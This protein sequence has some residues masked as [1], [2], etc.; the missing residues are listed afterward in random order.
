MILFAEDHYAINVKVG[1]SCGM[2]AVGDG[3]QI[4]RVD[5][6]RCLGSGHC[7]PSQRHCDGE[8]DCTD[9]SDEHGCTIGMLTFLLHLG[10]YRLCSATEWLTIQLKIHQSQLRSSTEN[11]TVPPGGSRKLYISARKVIEL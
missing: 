2:L 11:K 3:T 9:G 6:F 5:E 7:V 10:L 4:C 8:A 1:S